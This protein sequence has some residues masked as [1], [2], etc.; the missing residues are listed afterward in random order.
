MELGVQTALLIFKMYGGN[1]SQGRPGDPANMFTYFGPKGIKVRGVLNK[2]EV[3]MAKGTD[4][5]RGVHVVV[6]TPTA[7]LDCVGGK[8][9]M[10]LLNHVR[11]IA[12]DEYDECFDT[13]PEAMFVLLSI[14]TRNNAEK[15]QMIAVGATLDRSTAELA[16][17]AGWMTE[18]ITIQ[19]GKDQALPTGLTHQYIVVEPGRKLA[20][21]TRMLRQDLEL[22]GDDSVPARA[23]IFA[24][25]AEEAG[26][27]LEPLRSSL[28]TDHKLAVLLP[29]GTRIAPPPGSM[30]DPEVAEAMGLLQ[31]ASDPIRA[32]H[33]FRDNKTSLLLC[34]P[35]A[36]RGIDLP[37]VSHVYNLGLP[38]DAK[39]YLHRAGRAG[40]VGSTTGGVVTTLVTPAELEHIKAVGQELNITIKEGQQPGSILPG[41][42]EISEEL[43]KYRKGLDDLYNLM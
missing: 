7:L 39:Q 1:I 15:P 36:S 23:M 29:P 12:I 26:E 17:Q 21:L 24:N 31:Q 28:W 5:L 11:V 41:E 13:A 3:A 42:G 43:E 19:V 10:P 2:E 9:A 27:A 8:D 22:L 33:S 32:M 20:V 40:R 30:P 35:Q 37:A 4:Y 18:P 16:V 25:N 14:A 38:D 6:A 34:T